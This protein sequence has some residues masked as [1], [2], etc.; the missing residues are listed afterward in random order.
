MRLKMRCD[1]TGVHTLC[2]GD[3]HPGQVQATDDAVWILDL[4][5]VCI[6]DPAYDVAMV[7]SVFKRLRGNPDYLRSLRDAFVASYF[8]DTGDGLA[9]RV[10]V[11]EALIHLKR[12]CKRFRW[13]DETD[14]AT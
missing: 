11:Q 1:G 6:G 2:H 8:A 12:A 9:D 10:P 7:L 3:Y 13:Q 4:D 5:P 14:W